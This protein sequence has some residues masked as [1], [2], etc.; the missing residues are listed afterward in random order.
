MAGNHQVVIDLDVVAEDSEAL[1]RL[2]ECASL[3]VQSCNAE[4]TALGYHMLDLVGSVMGKQSQS[5][6]I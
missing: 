1:A 6:D 3:M 2:Y 4:E 5:P